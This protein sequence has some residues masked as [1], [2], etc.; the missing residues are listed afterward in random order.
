MNMSVVVLS[1]NYSDEFRPD[2]LVMG[3]E[4]PYLCKGYWVRSA[5][6]MIEVDFERRVVEEL[7]IRRFNGIYYEDCYFLYC[8]P[9]GYKKEDFLCE[10]LESALVKTRAKAYH[11]T[12]STI[13]DRLKNQNLA[14]QCDRYGVENSDGSKTMLDQE[15]G[16]IYLTG[17]TEKTYVLEGVCN[18]LD[19]KFCLR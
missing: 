1:H 12:P 7:T 6:D 14:R 2:V 4:E 5:G 19:N 10:W 15:R 9:S 8:L 18:W 16:I 11:T 3:K 13:D 17:V